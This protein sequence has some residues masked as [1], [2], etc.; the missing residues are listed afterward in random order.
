MLEQLHQNVFGGV[1]RA[2]VAKPDRD[3]IVEIQ[4]R[5]DFLSAVSRGTVEAVDA[6]NERRAAV[7][8]VVDHGEGALEAP[9]VGQDDGAKWVTA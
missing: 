8:E 9:G 2:D 3:P 7:F 1:A 5:P 6:D 4:R